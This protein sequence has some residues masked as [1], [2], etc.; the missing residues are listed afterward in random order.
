MP[1]KFPDYFAVC[2]LSGESV[3]HAVINDS[4][5]PRD[6]LQSIRREGMRKGTGGIEGSNEN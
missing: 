5:I 1:T 6:T 3:S 4:R 2:L